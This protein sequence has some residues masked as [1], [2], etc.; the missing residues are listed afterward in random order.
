[1]KTS[2]DDPAAVGRRAR[3][4]LENWLDPDNRAWGFQHVRELVPS[5]QIRGCSAP[6]PLPVNVSDLGPRVVMAGDVALDDYVTTRD[7]NGLL[8]MHRGIVRYETYRHGLA[9]RTPHLLMSVSKSVTAS[10]AGILVH[11]GYLATDLRISEI[12]PGLRGTGWDGATVED[13]LDMRAGIAF[14]E[15][16]EDPESDLFTYEQIYQW[17]PLREDLPLDIRDWM[18][19]LPADGTH[20][21]PFEYQSIVTDML[22]WVLES[23]THV[24]IAELI[25]RLLWRPI[26][27]EEDA[28][29]TVDRYG[30]GQ[31]DGGICA[32]LRDI[33]RL[34]E[35]WRNGGVWDDQE[36]IPR[37]W[38]EQTLHPAWVPAT[39]EFYSRHWWVVDPDR[40][41]FAARGYCGQAVYVD[42]AAELV[43]AVL[44]AW[45][46]H[47][48]EREQEVVEVVRAV[49]ELLD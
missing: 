31:A 14:D 48:A 11:R 42:T 20:G 36:V 18:A 30:N 26:G 39:S 25:S 1:M 19:A 28:Y 7:V 15:S 40:A 49:G 43:V 17:R 12:I 38:I 6:R 44:S 3:P 35:L 4:T 41:L 22:A 47:T 32:T 24:R 45:P 21:G 10:V 46:E 8:V 13:L 2:R 37:A 23:V 9:P 27:A 33:A 34:G 29:I 16:D 5:S